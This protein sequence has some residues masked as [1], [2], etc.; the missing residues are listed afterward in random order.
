[1]ALRRSIAVVVVSVLMVGALSACG[2]Q[3]DEPAIESTGTVEPGTG[4]LTEPPKN[5][6]DAASDANDATQ[7]TQ[8]AVDTL[9]GE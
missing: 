1:M 6:E 3:A 2:T 4:Y 9:E 8:E 5:A 7:D